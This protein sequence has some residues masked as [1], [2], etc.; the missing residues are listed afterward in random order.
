MTIASKSAIGQDYKPERA[1]VPGICD[2]SLR[3]E[4]PVGPD[5]EMSLRQLKEFC[6]P[7]DWAEVDAQLGRYGARAFVLAGG[8][9]VHGLDAR[10]LL[11]EVEALID[12]RNLGL[13]YIRAESGGL[14]IGAT[15]TFAH[16][17]AAPTLGESPWLGALADALACPPRQIRNV[18]TVGGSVAASCPYFDPP[19][20]LMALDARVAVVAGGARREFPLGELFAGTFENSL[21]RGEIIVELFL[22]RP[23]GRSASAFLKLEGNANDLAIVNCAASL[24]IDAQG[25][26]SEA[27]IALGGGVGD[28]IARATSAERL[29]Q[30]RVAD[31]EVLWSAAEAVGEDIDPH[32]DHRA[33][34][35]Y[36][37][38]VAKV[39]TRRALTCALARS[40]RTPT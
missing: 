20:A 36:R 15:T 21:R 5:Q 2:I 14:R 26:C 13:D 12:I 6:I 8:S 28:A 40:A 31:D 34:A 27:R 4:A 33:S 29:L 30:G 16:L 11:H 37:L 39:L 18:A 32:T 35:A 25:R 22:P 3:P 23:T 9:F 17:Q 38:A 10:G 19:T 24:E 1:D 7:G